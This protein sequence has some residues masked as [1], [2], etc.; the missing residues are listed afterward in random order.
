MDEFYAELWV[1]SFD[2][3]PTPNELDSLLGVKC[4]RGFLDVRPSTTIRY[5]S[6]WLLRS[7]LPGKAPLEDHVKDLLE[8]VSPI[9]EKIGSIAQRPNVE[10]Q[11]GCV[12]YTSTR[13][14]FYFTREQVAAICAMGAYID[15]DLYFLPKRT[16]RKKVSTDSAES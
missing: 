6:G 9:A 8:R 13:Q 14:E 16:R 15:V 12:I 1:R 4:D 10:V 11:F 3:T 7:R 5:K 2:E